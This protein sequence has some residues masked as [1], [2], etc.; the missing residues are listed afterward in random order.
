M[1]EHEN[2]TS[3]SHSPPPRRVAL[4]FPSR[5][6]QNKAIDLFYTDPA[7]RDF[8]RDYAG[9]HKIIVTEDWVEYLRVAGLTFESTTNVNPEPAEGI[10][11]LEQVRD[12]RKMRSA[13]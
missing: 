5:E 1:R 6:E 12:E 10:S 7:L 8:P 4:K 11:F 2:R 13:R 9:G 3:P